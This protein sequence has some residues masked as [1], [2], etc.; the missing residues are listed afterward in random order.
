MRRL[1][2]FLLLFFQCAV[3][4]TS[5][6]KTWATYYN[7]GF[8]FIQSSTIDKDGNVYMVGSVKQNSVFSTTINAFQSS[9]GGGNTDGFIT[10]FSPNGSVVWATFFGGNGDEIIK[11]VVID[12]QNNV[13]LIGLTSSSSSIATLNSFR[14]TIPGSTSSFIT[15][16]NS[17]GDLGWSTYYTAGGS[18]IT[19]I[20]EMGNDYIISLAD[21]VFFNG[22]IYVFSNT[23]ENNQATIGVF[24]EERQTAKYIVSKFSSAGERVW[25]SYYGIN[26]SLIS[27][28]CVNE[29][30]VYLSGR[31][32][33]CDSNP[34]GYFATQGCFQTENYSECGTPFISKFNLDGQREWSTYFGGNNIQDDIIIKNSIKC[35]G[36]HIYFVGV[37]YRDDMATIGSYQESK[38][39]YFCNYL[40]KFN[41]LGERIWAT[42]FGLNS[43][44]DDY[45]SLQNSLMIDNYENVYVSGVTNL[46]QNISTLNCYQDNINT[47]SSTTD[48]KTD[49]YVMKFDSEGERIFGT[50]FGGSHDEY[51]ASI[52]PYENKFYLYGITKSTS[53]IASAN[54]FQSSFN[55]NGIVSNYD[56]N[57]FLARFD[58]VNLSSYEILVNSIKIYPNPAK[59]YIILSALEND[60]QVE[61]YDMLGKKI[62]QTQTLA[63][64]TKINIDSI[65]KGVYLVKISNSKSQYLIQKIII[66]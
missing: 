4:Q 40:V 9:Y 1:S 24:Q 53:N 28:L 45:Y 63:F 23:G 43:I 50:Y 5:F 25:S 46:Q 13:Y 18:D 27:G 66:E 22:N 56:S 32:S 3:S 20:G 58:P 59:E 55:M 37:T 8:C 10:K 14:S 35:Y 57:I 19:L 62:L 48:F 38:D 34:T 41:L 15:K 7:D 16:F 26:D 36:N 42:Y 65:S 39:N 21:I 47:P 12:S 64:Q 49:V 6:E 61:I 11:G 52:L 60:L 44:D 31:S 33:S 54:S 17:E 2:F 51:Y 30:G 29:T